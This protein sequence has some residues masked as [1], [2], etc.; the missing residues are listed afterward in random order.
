MQCL[1]KKPPGLFHPDGLFY[2]CFRLSR[3][4]SAKFLTLLIIIPPVPSRELL[5]PVYQAAWEICLI[6]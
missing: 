1:N 4:Y 2:V 5:S 6:L 3:G